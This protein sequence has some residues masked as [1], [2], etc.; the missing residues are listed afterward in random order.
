MDE[1]L[2][3][4][5]IEIEVNTRYL[6]AESDPE[7]EKYVFIYEIKIFNCGK[8]SLQLLSR[9]WIITDGNQ[10]ILE[11]EGSGVVGQQPRIEPGEMYQYT[12]GTVLETPV[13][14]MRGSYNMITDDG[15]SFVAQIPEFGLVAPG[16]LH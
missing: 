8:Q 16:L 9:H 6:E 1:H 12:S 2:P 4:L 7:L 5:D 11:V 10:Q 14:T 15:G 3:E 13:G